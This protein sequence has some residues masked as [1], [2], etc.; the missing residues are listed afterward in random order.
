MSASQFWAQNK[1][2][3]SSQNNQGKNDEQKFYSRV[4]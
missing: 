1:P 3:F 2:T 4:S